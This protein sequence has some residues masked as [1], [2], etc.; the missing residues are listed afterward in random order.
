M[1]KS[2]FIA[3][4]ISVVAVLWVLSGV[5][6]EK[7]N[8][9]NESPASTSSSSQ[10]NS[11]ETVG[12]LKE[13]EEI[14]NKISEVRVRHLVAQEMDDTVEVTGRTQASRQVVIRSEAEGQIATLNVKKGDVVVKGQILARLAVRDRAARVDEAKQLLKQRQIQYNASKELAEKG[15]NSRVRLAEKEAELKSARAQV[16]QRQDELLSLIHI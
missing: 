15:F 7:N 9:I 3:L 1:K 11:D 10:T 12:D 6:G 14:E 5:V 8:P 4:L 16:K 13:P 2:L